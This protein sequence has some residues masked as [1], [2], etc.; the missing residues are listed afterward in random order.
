MHMFRL[1]I[2]SKIQIEVNLRSNQVIKRSNMGRKRQIGVK[3]GQ[4]VEICPI[5]ICFDSEFS[6]EFRF[7]ILKVNQG[8]QRSNLGQN[9]QKEVE[10]GRL[11]GIYQIYIFFVSECSQ[12]FKF[13]IFQGQ[14]GSS[15]VELGSNPSNGGQI[16]S[17][18][19][20]ISN[21]HM[22]RLRILSAIEIENYLGYNQEY[23]T[24]SRITDVL[25]IETAS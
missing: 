12:E 25:K 6:R 1:E 15:E 21:I 11:V 22:F 4:V 17:A 7:N 14:L 5:Y 19:R 3:T 18:G 10:S 20:T 2:L 16:G 23:I 8:H 13:Y 24:S 9:R